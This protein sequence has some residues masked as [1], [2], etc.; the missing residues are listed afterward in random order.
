M[1]GNLIMPSGFYNEF[2][3]KIHY[4]MLL[5]KEKIKKVAKEFESTFGRSYGNGLVHE[6]RMNDA[7]VAIINYGELAMQMEQAVDDLREEGYKVGCVKL[8]YFRP[9]PVEDIINIAR[10]VKVLGV[11]DRATAFGSP[12]GGP[13]SSEVKST[14]YNT[15]V[16]TQ[17]LPIIMG[18]G[19]R[20]V[21]LEQQK[22]QLKVL[23]KLNDTGELPKDMIDGTLWDGLL[24]VE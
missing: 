7:D 22:N 10:K 17:I 1:H 13:V 5:A 23:I 16:S 9:F 3:L 6:Y 21:T 19:G 4:T 24:E 2:R 12:T 14:L 20:E 11:A 18:L 8:R 15:G